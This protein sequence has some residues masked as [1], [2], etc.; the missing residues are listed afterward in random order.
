MEQLL[1]HE[2]KYLPTSNKGRGIERK[3]RN[4]KRNEKLVSLIRAFLPTHWW[5]FA[6]Y[7]C[8]APRESH[9][10]LFKYNV[11]TQP[12]KILE[13]WNVCSSLCSKWCLL[14]YVLIK[15]NQWAFLY[16]QTPPKQDSWAL[17][18]PWWLQNYK[19]VGTA[20]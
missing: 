15:K 3:R 1:C 12:V 14:Y 5:M 18:A 6:D 16:L 8:V 13:L 19:K 17:D 7:Y 9:I 10:K 4:L 2:T 20:C 11:I